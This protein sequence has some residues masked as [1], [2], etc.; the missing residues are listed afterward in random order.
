M[1]DSF[2]NFAPTLYNILTDETSRVKAVKS[3][4]IAGQTLNAMAIE[5]D[6]DEADEAVSELVRTCTAVCTEINSTPHL[7]AWRRYLRAV[8][9]HE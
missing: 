6:T 4:N 8:W 9:L 7:A 2:R 1:I 5:T 3:L